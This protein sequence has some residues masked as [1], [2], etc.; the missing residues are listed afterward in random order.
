MNRILIY[1][2]AFL[3]DLVLTS[4][5][6]KSVKKTFPD[7]ELTLM[8]RKGLGRVFEGFKYLD[9]IIEREDRNLIKLS[10][11]VKEFNFDIVL[12]PH[13]SHRTSLA[14]FLSGI[15]ERVGFD[16]SG[17]SFLYTKKVK[18]ER[19]HEIERNLDLLKAVS[20]NPVMD[21]KPELPMNSSF[22]LKTLERFSLKEKTYVTLSPGS[23]WETKRWIPEYFAEVGNHFFNR[24]FKIVILGSK[25]EKSICKTVSSRIPGSIDLSGETGID[26]LI[27]IIK[28]AKLSITNDSAPAHIASSFETPV[29]TIFGSTVKDFGFYPYGKRSAIAEVKN[30]YCRPC[31]IH[32]RR[33]CP[34]KHF[35]CMKDLKPEIVIK[36]SEKLLSEE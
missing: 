17:F 32:G 1:Q 6:I 21:R 8:T 28:G 20:E 5:L 14:L 25:S 7:S 4:P 16:I 30:L 19:K 34:E 15:K 9:R 26:E 23:E 35:K 22:Y 31:G 24:G 2:T 10:K 11:T 33:K 3:G 18:Y 12:S 27:A 36:L 13:R 29:V